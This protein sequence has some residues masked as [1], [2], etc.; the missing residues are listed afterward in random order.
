MENTGKDLKKQL[1]ISIGNNVRKCRMERHLTQEELAAL[2]DVEQSTITRI[3]G[4]QR[5]MSI[6][7]LHAMA[8][9][10]NVSYDALLR[11]TDVDTRVSNIAVQLSGQSPENLARLEHIIQAIIDAYGTDNAQSFIKR[12]AWV[13][14]FSECSR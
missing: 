2:V 13:A 12:N 14:N 10:L 8:G 4:G 6:V 11:G 7:M 5:M 9:A 1:M 3:E